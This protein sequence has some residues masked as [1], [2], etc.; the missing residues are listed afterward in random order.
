MLEK[1]KIQFPDN[2]VKEVE[3]GKLAK[4]IIKD[5]IG[6]GLL[7]A[8][9][10]VMINDDLKDLS[11][12][13]TKDCKFK[14]IT[15]KDKEALEIIKHSSAHILALAVKRLFPKTKLTIGPAIENGFY[16]DFD[17]EK[18]FTEE[19]LLKIE[20]EGLKIIK[21]DIVFER[22]DVDY[23]KA[24]E[25]AKDEPYKLEMIEELKENN[26]PLSF[27]KLKDWYELCRG[28]HVE[29]TGKIKAFKLT[30]ISGA[31]WKADSKN[32]QLQRIYGV[33]FFTKDELKNYIKVIEEAER[34]DHR[35]IG[36]E[37]DLYSFHEEA[38]GM[39]FFHNKGSLIWN[40]LVD[41]VTE[42]MISRNYEINKTPIILNKNLWLQSGH[43][44]HYKNNMYFTKIDDQDFA[45][46]PMNCPGN[47][48]IYK[49]HQYSY[50][51]LPI[52]AGEFGLV[53]RHELS[54]VLSGLFRV[55]AF[56]QDDAHVFC[57]EEQIKE[58]IKDLI[59]FMDVVYK[60]FGFDYTMELSTKPEKALGSKDLWDFAEQKLKEVLEENKK[61]YK[62]NPGDGAFYGPK[63][64]F[65]LKDAIGRDWQ[66]GTIQ[67]DFQ[68]PEKFNLTYEAQNNEKKRPVMIHRAVLG[69]VERFMG[70]LVEHFEG[71]FPLWISP[72][73]II[74]LPIADR[75]IGYCKS[76][77]EE[78]QNNN[79]TVEIND[80]AETMNKK[81]RNAQLQ[82]INYII[83]VG[84]KEET[85]KTIN[86]RT[87][88]E[89]ILG[90]KRVADFIKELKIEIE[91]KKI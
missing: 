26:E 73:Q 48:L 46:K 36:R 79:F 77:Q 40:K 41:F 2:S 30:K 49:S 50:R 15:S 76:V 60:T 89:K 7:R 35:K 80:K 66:C 10:A 75:H 82:K 83:V 56:T 43:W 34:R 51:D 20:E 63:I 3:I 14:V 31:Y 11:T 13:I 5:E 52:R 55:R 22:L 64:D 53:H 6:E 61:E 18:P 84:D 78:L 88:D 37:L 16:Y 90:E 44:D 87:R 38:P 23:N 24:I 62:L 27:Y 65:H 68:M 54:G 28:P 74:L 67:L 42:I 19:D 12:P 47:I 59:N 85:N 4:D 25:L 86:V 45:V 8:S 32:K 1:I 9:I 21:E 58:E 17:S 91:D 57:T 72:L 71:K 70:I 69:S 81:I 33:S 39:P 29:S